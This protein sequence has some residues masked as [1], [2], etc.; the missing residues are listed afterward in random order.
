[1]LQK[2]LMLRHPDWPRIA[3]YVH[4]TGAASRAMY[5]SVSVL[6]GRARK[7]SF[8]QQVL[9]AKRGVCLSTLP[10]CFKLGI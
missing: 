8:E 2:S 5:I 6:L 4:Q 1:M 3:I 10:C 9:E 7:S